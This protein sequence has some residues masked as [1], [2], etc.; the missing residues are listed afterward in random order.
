MRMETQLLMK[1][2]YLMVVF[3]IIADM[4]KHGK[5]QNDDGFEDGNHIEILVIQLSVLLFMS[6]HTPQSH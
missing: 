1:F 5:H 6:N 2:F 3:V 4:Y